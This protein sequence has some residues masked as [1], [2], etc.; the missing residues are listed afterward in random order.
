L[1]HEIYHLSYDSKDPNEVTSII[2][3]TYRKGIDIWA[4]WTNVIPVQAEVNKR[5]ILDEVE[6]RRLYHGGRLGGTAT[7]RSYSFRRSG[8]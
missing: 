5:D 3:K 1:N 4:V 7:N 2:D 8:L 6:P